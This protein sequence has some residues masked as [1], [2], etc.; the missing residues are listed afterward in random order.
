LLP[1]Y[2]INANNMKVLKLAVMLLSISILTSFTISCT[3]PEPLVPQCTGT[4][5]WCDTIVVP[6][7]VWRMPQGTINND[8]LTIN[9]VLYNNTVVF[10]YTNDKIGKEGVRGFDKNTGK[11]L[12]ETNTRAEFTMGRSLVDNKLIIQDGNSFTALDVN[13]GNIIGKFKDNQ[14]YFVGHT[15]FYN[16]LYAERDAE[17]F[18]KGGS[19]SIVRIGANLKKVETIYTYIGY[20]GRKDTTK[21]NGCYPPSIWYN[22]KDTLMI[23]VTQSATNIETETE[24]VIN[25]INL[26]TR[27]LLWQAQPEGFLISNARHLIFDNKIIIAYAR[28]VYCLDMNTGKILWQQEPTNGLVTT[29]NFVKIDNKLYFND[30]WDK[31]Y[32]LDIN[33]GAVIYGLEGYSGNCSE[34]VEHKGI[35]YYTGGNGRL[36]AVEATSGKKLWEQKSPNKLKYS[37]TNFGLRGVVIDKEK[38][39]LYVADRAEV[40][41][42]ELAKK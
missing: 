36:Y 18:Y 33:T 4:E 12:W 40:F 24:T 6:K 20:E 39:R 30:N 19:A 17:N 28:F 16:Y 13:N 10:S 8:Q 29:A 41:C 11:V 7:I 15:N 27:Q 31:L 23:F 38:E 5:W 37:Y 2:Y 34:M 3:K 14:P 1:S 32:C 35:L 21:I 26:K 9:P 42:F 25:C 22:G